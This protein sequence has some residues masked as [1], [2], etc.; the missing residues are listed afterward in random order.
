M[1]WIIEHCIN[2]SWENS[3]SEGE[4]YDT[5]EEAGEELANFIE[6]CLQE[7]EEGLLFDAPNREDYRIT[8]ISDEHNHQAQ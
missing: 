1:S 4:A 8:E 3:S 6:S 5:E 7:V 2:G